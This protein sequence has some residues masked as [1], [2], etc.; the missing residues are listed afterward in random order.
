MVTTNNNLL[1]SLGVSHPSL[2]KI[3]TIADYSGFSSK[4]TGAGGG[5]CCFILLPKDYKNNRKFKELCKDLEKHNF[6]FLETIIEKSNGV[7][8]KF[9][10]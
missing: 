1:R 2:E 7:N 8:F 5:G 6:S 9:I 3:F 4:L 10:Q